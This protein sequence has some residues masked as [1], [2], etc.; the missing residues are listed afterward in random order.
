VA[1][2]EAIASEKPTVVKIDVEGYELAVL[3]GARRTLGAPEL[4]A[5]I[6]EINASESRYGF[7]EE[8][9]RAAMTSMGFTEREYDPL[10]RALRPCGAVRRGTGNALFVR[11][12]AFVA[13]RLR[14]A[15]PVA[16]HGRRL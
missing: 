12:E 11:D 1:L 16:V 8:E 10:R 4:K 15:S 9:T 2:D 14:G 7:R 13:G 3:R 5:V 6:V